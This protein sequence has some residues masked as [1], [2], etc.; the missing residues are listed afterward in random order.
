MLLIVCA[1]PIFSQTRIQ[2]E[3]IG[4]F[5]LPVGDF[6]R[7]DGGAATFGWAQNG[8]GFGL[9]GIYRIN[10]TIGAGVEGFL[11]YNALDHQATDDLF[12]S[13]TSI[14][15]ISSGGNY[16]NFPVMGTLSL[17]F[18]HPNQVGGSL[19]G[20]L[21]VDFIKITEMNL[22]DSRTTTRRINFDTDPAF[23]FSWGGKMDFK[24][25]FIGLGF[26]DLGRHTITS[27]VTGSDGADTSSSTHTFQI[28][29]F[30]V[31]ADF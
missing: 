1:F 17:F 22:R 25:Y 15:V 6:A 26:M 18:P 13:A 3:I 21:G 9:H 31:G 29:S 11:L 20:G 27:T 5:S 24:R 19:Y 10:S 7:K 12:K 16:F 28:V 23:A 14:P 2:E 8:F 30:L 4:V